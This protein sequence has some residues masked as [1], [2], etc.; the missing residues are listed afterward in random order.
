MFVF[1]FS[2]SHGNSEIFRSGDEIECNGDSWMFLIWTCDHS[3]FLTDAMASRWIV[4][5]LPKSRYYQTE[6]G[7]LSLEAI[8]LQITQSFNKL[9][10]EGVKVRHHDGIR[11]RTVP[12]LSVPTHEAVHDQSWLSLRWNSKASLAKV[13]RLRFFV[14]GFRGDWKALKEVFSFVR[15]YGTNEARPSSFRMRYQV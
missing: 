15:H 7:N 13:A 11:N 1:N 5:I 9:S 4:G 6:R 3:P 10:E 8:T 2:W 12:G 14:T